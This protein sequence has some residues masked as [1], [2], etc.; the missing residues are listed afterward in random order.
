MLPIVIAA[1]LGVSLFVL[2]DTISPS[3]NTDYSKYQ[4]QKEEE[5]AVF[6]EESRGVKEVSIKLC[7][8]EEGK[9]V[10][11]AVLCA[12]GND[13]AVKS[14]IIRLLSAALG[15]PTNKIEVSGKG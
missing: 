4:D 3:N 12:G 11:A 7:I 8:D 9:I 10:G 5:L 6:L 1:L 2:S 14:Q 15:L 13:P